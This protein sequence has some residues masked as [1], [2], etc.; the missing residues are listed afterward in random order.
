MVKTTQLISKNNNRKI[1]WE[2]HMC[3]CADDSWLANKGKNGRHEISL[4]AKN[5][6][7]N[8]YQFYWSILVAIDQ[9]CSIM[10]THK[11]KALEHDFLSHIVWKSKLNQSNLNWL[12]NPCRRKQKSMFNFLFVFGYSFSPFY[13]FSFLNTTLQSQTNLPN[14]C[15]H[16][17]GT[18]WHFR[19]R[20]DWNLNSTVT[21]CTLI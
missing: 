4:L 7:S 13:A 16:L 19:T 12:I 20:F 5:W 11:K 14:N 1:E 8:W 17:I 6:L 3:M 18:F 9:R 2:T 10:L 21:I 15:C